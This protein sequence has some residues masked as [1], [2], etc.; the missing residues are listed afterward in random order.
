MKVNTENCD[1]RRS[2]NYIRI[3]DFKFFLLNFKFCSASQGP[4]GDI[5]PDG[6]PGR[7]GEDGDRGE[8]GEMGDKG[9]RVS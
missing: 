2:R 1:E 8:R 5:G 7:H 6:F 4:P 9:H 3:R